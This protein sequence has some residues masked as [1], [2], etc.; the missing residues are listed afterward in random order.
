M[1]RQFNTV[2][3]WINVLCLLLFMHAFMCAMASSTS[4]GNSADAEL[5]EFR[6]GELEAQLKIMP[7]SLERDYF[8]GVLANQSQS[9]PPA[10]PNS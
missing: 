10:P 9:S 3:G 4:E 1:L 6:L 2:S 5:R 8:A 7:P